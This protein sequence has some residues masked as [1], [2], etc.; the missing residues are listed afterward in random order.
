M[1]VSVCDIKLQ[2][3]YVAYAF[4][5]PEELDS[6]TFTVPLHS[7][8][9]CRMALS[10]IDPTYDSIWAKQWLHSCQSSNK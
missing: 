10:L 8:V 9:A 1:D 3:H 5:G 2:S 6:I 7:S 4:S